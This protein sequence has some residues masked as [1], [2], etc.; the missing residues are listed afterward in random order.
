M[1]GHGTFADDYEYNLQTLKDNV[2]LLTPEILDRINALVVD[3][4]HSLV[5]KNSEKLKGRCDSFVVDP[6]L[7]IGNVI[8]KSVKFHVMFI[9]T[10]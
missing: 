10:T 5:K 9:V 6:F 8:L 2:A 1:L 4:G 3:A 7:S